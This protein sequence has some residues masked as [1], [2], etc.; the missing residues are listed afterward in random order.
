MQF[1]LR[2]NYH[3]VGW[4]LMCSCVLLANQLLCAVQ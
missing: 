4:Q 1:Y 3:G 2:F